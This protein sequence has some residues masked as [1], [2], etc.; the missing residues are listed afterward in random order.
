MSR[1]EF[2][3]IS[4]GCLLM[5]INLGRTWRPQYLLEFTILLKLILLHEIAHEYD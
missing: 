5:W 2:T 1:V 3:N 4:E